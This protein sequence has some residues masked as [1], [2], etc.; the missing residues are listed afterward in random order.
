MNRCQR[1][2]ADIFSQ[3]A[4][5]IARTYMGQ[6]K[7][8]TGQYFGFAVTLPTV[9]VDEKVVRDYIKRQETD[10]HR[11]DQLLCLENNHL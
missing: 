4:I 9:G 11:L 7:N 2:F 1:Q 6:K 5:Q 10:D 3:S 8:F